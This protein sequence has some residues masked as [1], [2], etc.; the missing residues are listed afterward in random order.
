MWSPEPV[1][2]LRAKIER[3]Q[4]RAK[5]NIEMSYKDK[6]GC[7]KFSSK[8]KHYPDL[9]SDTHYQYGLSGFVPWMSCQVGGGGGWQRGKPVVAA[10]DVGFFIS[11]A[12]SFEICFDQDQ[13]LSVCQRSTQC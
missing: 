9:G 6:L 5:Q 3:A 10:V 1:V 12:P 4:R 11:L 8:Q 2:P 13:T 7:Y